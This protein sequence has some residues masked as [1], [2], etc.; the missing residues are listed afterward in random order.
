MLRHL[1]LRLEHINLEG[2][3]VIQ[4]IVKPSVV[5]VAVIIF[6]LFLQ[7]SRSASLR[8]GNNV[9]LEEVRNNKNTHMH[10]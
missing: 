3:C 10:A 6:V 2:G 5:F 4:P 1:G 7:S 9:G 8:S